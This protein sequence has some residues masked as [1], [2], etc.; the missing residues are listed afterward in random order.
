M[1]HRL[2]AVVVAGM[3]LAAL[4][5]STLA[6]A[7]TAKTGFK[8]I[9]VSGIKPHLDMVAGANPLK[10]VTV[11]VGMSGTPLAQRIADAKAAG[12]SLSKAQQ[13]QIV[14]DNKASIASTISKA[15]AL[16]G[17]LNETYAAALIGF[18][19]RIAAGRIGAL[20]SLPG[21]TSVQVAQPFKPDNERSVPFI[22]APT[23]WGSYGFTGA[24]VKVGDIDTGIDYY[25]ANFG[26]SGNAADFA[27]DNGLTIGTPA[28]PNAKVAGGYDF[29]GDAY[30]ADT[31]HPDPDPLDCNGHGSHTAG[32][33]AGFGVLS[34]GSTFSGRYD[35]TTVSSH[36]WNIGP[37]V[38]PQA[39]IYA[40]RVFGCN[41]SANDDVIIAAIDQSVVDGVDVVNMSLGAPFGSNDDLESAAV[42]NA[43]AAG[44]LIVGS[45][46][47]AGAAPYIDGGPCVA[48]SAIC[49]AAMDGGWANFPGA[50]I[51]LSTGPTVTAINENVATF[52]DGTTLPVK[53]IYT[54]A[55]HDLDHISLGCS[56]A[57]YAGAV[58]MIAVV[59][60]GTCARVARAIFAQEAGAA[61]V[62]MINNSA[63][64]PPLDGPI[65]VNPDTGQ[66]YT[67][68]I[69]LLGVTN[70]ST[71]VNALIEADAAAGTGTLTNTAIPNPGYKALASFSSGGPRTGDS[72]LK[73][74]L[75]A[76]G[77]STLSTAVG[78]GNQGEI[79]SGTSMAAPHVTGSAALVVEAHPSWTP[80]QIKAALMNTS[81]TSSSVYASVPSIRLGGAGVVQ[82]GKA[83]DTQIIATT[84]PGT[85][86]ISYG[87][88][89]IGSPYSAT[90]PITFWNSGS[91]AVT[92]NL[93]SSNQALLGGTLSIAKSSVT[94]PAGGSATVN[95]KLTYSAAAVAALPAAEASQCNPGGTCA[96]AT[97]RGLVLAT[98]STSGTGLYQLRIPW[99]V[100]PRGTSDIKATPT[101]VTFA[102]SSSKT[103]NLSNSGIHDGNA[104]FYALGRTSSDG[105]L[106]GGDLR[107]DG[108][109]SLAGDAKT[110]DPS[111]KSLVF[112]ANTWHAWSNPAQFEIDTYVDTNNDGTPEFDVVSAD[113]GA[114]TAGSF[115]GQAATFIFTYPAFHLVDVW[116]GDEPMN[117]S[118][119]E[120]FAPASELG[121]SATHSAFQYEVVSFNVVNGVK[122]SIGFAEFDAFN[123]PVNTGDYYTVPAGV[124]GAV[125]VSIDRTNLAA[126]PVSGWLIVT[127]DDEAGAGQADIVGFTYTP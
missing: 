50:N 46:G 101:K 69:P 51:A 52:S 126:T 84:G 22:G 77:V 19:V 60:R 99:L 54:S 118:T 30:N 123:Q 87:A 113:F 21:V 33:A 106:G 86:S 95:V 76:P 41:G 112:A 121:L 13:A 45:A 15:K 89:A 65:T 32:T 111:G 66:K 71:T 31:P 67:V 16:G 110:G 55:T 27:A 125:P 3:L 107:A 49:V 59:K 93:S 20:E 44:T 70:S 102:A 39:T 37:G 127:L 35:A 42:N 105:S 85:S 75:A 57:D 78:S 115:T 103:L 119:K 117:G 29:V 28:F 56:V 58:G 80:A 6:T 74:D 1:R 24:G 81:S 116:L 53:V 82:P 26:G 25:H 48:T 17:K 91:S 14:K 88:P 83:V 63:G 23:A 34:D 98:P 122:D 7:P 100:A 11:V 73:P 38:A 104:D 97:A 43:A 47:N 9:D 62:I 120:L 79:L 40:Y 96:L 108:V 12:K 8:R 92:L 114:V 72:A 124:S 61:G 64:L 94:V 10:Q 2:F 18:S 36:T 4:V 68:T 90:V 5:P 109:Q